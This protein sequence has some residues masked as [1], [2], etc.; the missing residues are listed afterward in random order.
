MIDLSNMNTE[1][2]KKFTNINNIPLTIKYEYNDNIVKD[3]VISQSIKEDTLINNE[4]KLVVIMSKGK[5]PITIYKENNVNELGNIPIIMY[6]GIHNLKNCDTAYTGGNVDRMGYNRTT[7]AFLNDLE[8]YYQKG[9]RMIRL[10]DY[11]DGNIKVELGKS[12]IILTFDD[13][14]KNNIRILGK[15]DKGNL[16]IDPNSAVGILEQFKQKY[17]DY[18]IT[19]TFFLNKYLFYQY[20]YNND[21]LKWLINHGYDI[22]N[23]T[24]NHLKIANLTKEETMKEIATMY[25]QLDNII[26]NK[27]IKILSL[28]NG[29]PTNRDHSNFPSILNGTYNNYQYNTLS[30][31]RVG[32]EPEYSPYNIKFDKTYLKRV[33]AWDN[34]GKD[35]LIYYISRLDKNRYISSGIDNKIVIPKTFL[36]KL[37]TNISKEVITYE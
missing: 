4:S 16:I 3:K 11:I 24:S 8:M 29:S 33:R 36:N 32:W 12:P 2:I 25:Q 13:G 37:N 26:P 18:N 23:H 14:A 30:T 28:P 1:Q 7:E 31:L 34:N 17:S 15:D 27:Y 20:E 5:F 6:H 22:G 21:I 35:D 10:Q 9:Y 19:A